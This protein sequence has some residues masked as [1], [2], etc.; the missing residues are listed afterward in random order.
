[1]SIM[2]EKRNREEKEPVGEPGDPWG[3]LQDPAVRALLD[4]V[5]EE[6]AFEFVRLMRAS[7]APE[8]DGKPKEKKP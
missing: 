5:A 7:V 2:A 1:M 8:A 6:L 4:H 3:F